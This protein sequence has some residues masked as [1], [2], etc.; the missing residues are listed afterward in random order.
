MDRVAAVVNDG[1]VSTSDLTDQIAMISERLQAQR[2][3]LPPPDVL[4]KQVLDRLIVQ[5]IQFQRAERVGI[6]ISEEQL[7]AALNDIAK[8]NN[9][10]LQQLPEALTAQG[11]DYAAY[12]ENI[13]REIMLTGLRQ[14]EMQRRVTITPR[15]LDQFIQKQKNLPSELNE[16]NVSHILIAV[17]QDATPAQVEQI[18]AKAQDIYQRAKDGEDFAKMAVANSNS[19]TALDGGA[20]GWRKGPELPT[21]LADLVIKMKAGDVSEPLRTPTGFHLVKLNDLRGTAGQGMVDQ[22]HVRH[23]LLKP[24]ALQDDATVRQRL[25]GIRERVLKG[26]DFAVFASSV[27]EDSGS[28]V[29]GGDLGWAGPGSYVPEFEAVVANLKENEISEP[30]HSP[31]GWHIAQLLGRRKF[32]TTDEVVRERAYAQLRESKADEATE[33]WLRELRDEAFVE[34]KL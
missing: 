23:I 18:A 11:L 16:Y 30:F 12:R 24:N 9:M 32:D 10:T 14:R 29:N 27:S 25:E 5:E 21:F 6:K 15:E 1:V 7:N 13:R 33:L 8:R 20:L 31:F 4:R 2:L 26:E 28:T 3:E 19:Q 17:P 22:V 34:Y